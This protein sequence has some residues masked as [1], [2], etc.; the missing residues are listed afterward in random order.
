MPQESTSLVRVAA[1]AKRLGIT[2]ETLRA[3]IN[4][5]RV[6]AVRPLGDRG[7]YFVPADELERLATARGSAPR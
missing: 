1:A 5:G 3:W 7:L 4:A 2:G 6:R